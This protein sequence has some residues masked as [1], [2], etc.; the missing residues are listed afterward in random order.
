MHSN[1]G[2]VLFQVSLTIFRLFAE[3]QGLPAKGVSSQGKAPETRTKVKQVHAATPCPLPGQLN[4]ARI[5]YWSSFLFP[6]GM[7][8]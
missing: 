3:G 5:M 1:A 7:V 2:E 4:R 8:T 6:V